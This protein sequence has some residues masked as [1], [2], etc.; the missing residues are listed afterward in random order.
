MTSIVTAVFKVTIGL[1]VDKGRNMAAEK[2]KDGDVTH[3][4]F[5]GLIIREIDDIKSKLDGLSRKDLLVSIIF[6]KEGIELLYEVFDKA[7]SKSDYGAITAQAACVETL[8]LTEEMRK[9]DLTGLDESAVRK[10]SSAKKRFERAREKATEAFANEALNTSDRILAMQYRI[11]ATILETVDNPADALAPCRVCIEDLNCLSVVQNSFDVQLKKGVQT[12]RSLFSKEERRK[13][14]SSVCHVNRVIHDVTLTVLGKIPLE[15]WP[16]VDTGEE[17]VDPLRDGRV[18]KALRNQG[19]EHCCVSWSF[20]QEGEEEHKLKYPR[21]ITTNSRGEFIVADHGDCNV[22]VFDRSGKFVKHFSP[23]VDDVNTKVYIY[24]VATD[25][26]DNI[27]VLARLANETGAGIAYWIYKFT[28][29]ASLRHKFL[30]REGAISNN[31]SVG[32][33]GNVIVL[34]RMGEK[35]GVD[36]HDTDG[37]FVRSFGEGILT[38][39]H[40]W[41]ITAANDGGVMVVDKDDFCVHIFGEHGQHL[42]KFEVK[43]FN[44]RPEISFHWASEHFVVAGAERMTDLLQVDIYTKDGEFVRSAQIY[45]EGIWYLN[46]ITVNTEGRIAVITRDVFGKFKVLLV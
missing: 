46:A 23:P 12:V 8:S 3:Q 4:K 38:R 39:W 14:I 25:M 32:E 21:G 15:L 44:Y 22:K 34:W 27:Y 26:D 9:L 18:S 1:L 2:L 30:L 5:R 7:R 13:I 28:K 11:M 31:L 29:T 20:G 10:L 43:R 19:I 16:T 40:E 33:S 6:F 41:D 24:D 17:K 45:E 36:E 42:N 35:H 37:Q